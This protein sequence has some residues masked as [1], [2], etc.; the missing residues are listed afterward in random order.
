MIGANLGFRTGELDNIQSKTTN[1]AEA[2]A[3]YLGDVLSQWFQW[4]PD[5]ASKRNYATF[6]A[7]QS[8][9]RRAGLPRAAAELKIKQF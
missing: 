7:L 8:A 4:A 3:S 1:L 2:P 6:G 9:V 5:A